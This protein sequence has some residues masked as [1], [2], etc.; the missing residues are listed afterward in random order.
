MDLDAY[1][2]AHADEWARLD[3]LVKQRRLDGREGDELLDLYQRVSTHLSVVR[4]V[5][6]DPA[7]VAY[8]STLLARARSRSAGTTSVGWRDAARFWSSTFPGALYAVRRWWLTTMA[9][10][11]LVAWI[12]GWWLVA[13]PRVESALLTPEQ[14][15]ELVSADF[16]NYYSQHAAG[17]FATQVWVNN[18]WVSALCIAL[19]VLGFPVIYLLWS[20]IANLAVVGSVMWRHGRGDLFFGLILPHG[21]LELTAVFVAAGV[22]LRLF[23]AWIEPGAR[24]RLDAFAQAGRSAMAVALGLIGVLAV[25]GAI[26]AFVT[27]SGLPTWARIGVGAVA[28]AAFFGYVFVIGRRAYDSGIRGDLTEDERG[29]TVPTAG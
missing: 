4:S 20:N 26:E 2:V 9:V 21:L 11:L 17:A 22:G 6:P 28:E 7:L 1:A 29:A 3:A 18:A 13:N 15:E 27:P 10:N 25:S 16:E 5:S 23:Y 19:G 14:V 24:T 12:V 8:L